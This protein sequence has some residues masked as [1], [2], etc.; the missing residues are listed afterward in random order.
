MKGS[1]IQLGVG[2]T[3][4]AAQQYFQTEFHHKFTDAAQSHLKRYNL[5]NDASGARLSHNLHCA[6]QQKRR[7]TAREIHEGNQ[8]ILKKIACAETTL[9]NPMRHSSP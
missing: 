2:S 9:N 6:S 1:R 3:T 5:S 8:R 4:D 7:H